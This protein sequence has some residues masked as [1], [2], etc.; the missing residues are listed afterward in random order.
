MRP[1]SGEHGL[2]DLGRRLGQSTISETARVEIR[3]P[4]NKIG[5]VIG[6]K[7]AT[8]QTLQKQARNDNCSIIFDSSGPDGCPG[9][10]VIK[11]PS[12]G[13]L[14]FLEAEVKKLVGLDAGDERQNVFSGFSSAASAEGSSAA[15]AAGTSVRLEAKHL[16]RAIK[17]NFGTMPWTKIDGKFH[18]LAQVVL[19]KF[20]SSP[21][22]ISLLKPAIPTPHVLLPCIDSQYEPSASSLMAGVRAGKLFRDGPRHQDRPYARDQEANG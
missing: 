21:T 11:G 18:F 9:L 8:I 13:T 3:V 15:S 16:P 4:S 6:R 10:L 1:N 22:A 20:P 2:D 17:E 14:A 5:L 19:C 7:G 12:L